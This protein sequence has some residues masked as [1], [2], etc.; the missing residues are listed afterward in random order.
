VEGTHGELGAGFADRLS[1]DDAYR[2][3][4]FDQPAGGQVAAVAGDAN[5]TLRFAGEHRADFHALDTGRLNGGGEVFGDF[6]IDRNDD[7][8][9][10]IDLIFESDAT[11]DAVAQRLDDFARF[12][13]GLDDDAFCGAAIVFGDDDVLSDV[14]QTASEVAGVGRFKSRI[15]QTFTRAV[16]RDEVLQH[17]ETFAEVR[18]DGGLDDFARGLGHEAAHAGELADLLRRWALIFDERL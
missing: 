5:A 11:H 8:A 18:G 16:S 17:V 3:A 2:F 14:D 12:D 6:L 1:G 9:F 15:G 13:D 10:V 4:A 7:V